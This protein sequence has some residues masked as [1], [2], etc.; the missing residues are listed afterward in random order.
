[1]TEQNAFTTRWSY[2]HQI[3]PILDAVD[4]NPFEM[5]KL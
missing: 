4:L 3:D 1:M 2:K 5:C